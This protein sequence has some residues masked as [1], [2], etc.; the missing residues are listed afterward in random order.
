MTSGPRVYAGG[1]ARGQNLV[2]LKELG[3]LK[4]ELIHVVYQ[5]SCL[6]VCLLTFSNLNIFATSGPIIT[7]FYLNHHWGGGKA[8]LG[9][10]PD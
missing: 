5:L 7:K 3:R 2:H 4:G 10:G 8:A 6:A 1:G 9:F